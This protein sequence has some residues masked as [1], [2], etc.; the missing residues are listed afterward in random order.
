MSKKK[1]SVWGLRALSN[2]LGCGTDLVDHP[3]VTYSFT[4]IDIIEAFRYGV[5]FGLEVSGNLI[6]DNADVGT[7]KSN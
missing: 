1:E 6:N 3:E 4:H 7:R 2:K 5:N